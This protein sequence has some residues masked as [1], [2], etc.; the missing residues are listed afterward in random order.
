MPENSPCLSLPEKEKRLEELLVG[1]GKVLVAFSGG[2]DSTFLL[3]RAVTLL[4][5]D[6]VLA[7]TATSPI[8]PATESAAAG[9]LAAE[10]AA[11]HQFISTGELSLEPFLENR[12]DRCYHCKK[13][14]CRGLKAIAAVGTYRYIIDG[15]N[16]DDRFDYRPGAAA[17]RAC[18]IRSP[19]QEAA[20][21]KSEIR[22]LSRRDR[23]ST[24]NRPA[25]SCL[26]TRF[27]YGERLERR[28][29]ER[30][31]KAESYLRTLGLEQEL[32]VRTSGGCAR[33]EAAP[34]EMALLWERRREVV[35]Y[36]REIGFLHTALD[37]EGYS[38]GGM[39]RSLSP[40]PPKDPLKG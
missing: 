17:A 24:W 21:T 19:L 15:A 2:V 32:R 8:R 16:H 11:E 35:A 12:S 4:G 39:N 23:L 36:L 22:L 13:E 6:N 1:F 20:L 9:A 26:A 14:L 34:A 10:L 30:V 33:I 5:R 38:P 3:H 28:Q 25:E 40:S 31:E 27:P 29:I 37:L 18:G 7:V